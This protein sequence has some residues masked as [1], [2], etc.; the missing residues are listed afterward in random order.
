MSYRRLQRQDPGRGTSGALSVSKF[1]SIVGQKKPRRSEAFEEA[2]FCWRHVFRRWRF[3]GLLS[4]FVRVIA[5]RVDHAGLAFLPQLRVGLLLLLIFE[6][7]VV[8]AVAHG[9]SSISGRTN[10]KATPQVP[11]RSHDLHASL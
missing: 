10:R 7:F 9:V 6:D 4:V 8:P 11:C 1:K 2:L 5:H 3:F